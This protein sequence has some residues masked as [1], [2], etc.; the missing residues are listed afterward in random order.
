MRQE[1][2]VEDMGTRMRAGWVAILFISFLVSVIIIGTRGVSAAGFQP[3]GPDRYSVIMQKYI[4]HEWW[5]TSWTENKVVCSFEIDHEGLPTGGDI[6]DTCGQDIYDEWILTNACPTGSECKG[7]YLQFIKTE[8]KQRKVGVQQ[9]PAVVWV[10]LDGCVPYK[11]SF[12][13]DNLPTL[14]LTGEEPIQGEHITGLAGNAN[15]KSFTCDPVCQLDLLPTDSNG[16]S[17]EF[18]ANSS[19]GDSS[20]IYTARVRVAKSEDPADHSWYADVISSQWQGDPLAG[21]SQVWDVFPPVGGTPDWLGT[22]QRSEDLA[23]NVSYEYL[24]ANLIKQNVVD[25]S[26][27][28]GSGLMENGLANPC[29]LETARPAVNEWQNRFDTLIFEAALQTGVPARLLKNIFARESQF[30]PVKIPGHPEVGLGQMTD[31][32]AD[33]ILIWNPSF[34]EQFCPSN[35]DQAICK[36]KIYPQPEEGWQGIGLDEV[37]R[38]LLRRALVSSVDAICPECSMG[39]DLEKTEF[40]VGVFAQTLVASCRQTGKVVE[41][42]FN[43]VTGDEV[44]YEDLWRFTLVNYNAGPGCLGLAVDGTSSMGEPLDWEHLS[45]HLT[46]VCQ[47]AL[48][49][50]NDISRSVP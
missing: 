47:G 4:S 2:Y 8:P 48:N 36:T 9:A 35:L 10:T 43:I 1:T 31:G 32:G 22:P 7:Y 6:Y 42:N 23:T 28:D 27:C 17:I 40:S 18:W 37:E 21:C 24:A 46:P 19:Y 3:P 44:S 41:M 39:I 12:R 29:G 15:G 20:E 26:K 5:L 11:S 49:Y 16:L 34:Y 25:A 33:T 14:V 30:W 45:T 38:A 50:V 13:C